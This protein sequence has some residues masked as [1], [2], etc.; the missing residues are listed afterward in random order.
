[1]NIP[2]RDKAIME[3]E[4]CEGCNIYFARSH[5]HRVWCRHCWD[6]LTHKKQRLR[7]NRKAT[8]PVVGD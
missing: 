2:P 8:I 7:R 4:C 5:G 3:G 6:R 1:M